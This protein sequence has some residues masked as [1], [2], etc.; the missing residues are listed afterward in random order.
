MRGF[1]GLGRPLRGLLILLGSRLGLLFRTSSM[2]SS[3]LDSSVVR[4]SSGRDC[5]GD[6]FFTLNISFMCLLRSLWFCWSSAFCC[7]CC[8]CVSRL[9]VLQLVVKLSSPLHLPSSS[10]FTCAFFTIY[11]HF[12]SHL[13][14]S[15]IIISLSSHSMEFL[16]PLEF[17]AVRHL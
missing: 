13:F 10:Y 5:C 12:L 6:G 11:I 9:Y 14:N 1:V 4:D 7:C 8:S 16:F 3:A 15:F 2:D 17:S